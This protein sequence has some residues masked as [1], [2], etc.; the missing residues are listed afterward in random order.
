VAIGPVLAGRLFDVAGNYNIAF[1]V[2][3]A[4]SI[5]GIVLTMLLRPIRIKS[6]LGESA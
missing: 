4:V 2:T 1:W 5:I 6:K 3:A